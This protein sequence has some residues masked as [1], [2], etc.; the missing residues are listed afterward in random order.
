M[1]GS[2][3]LTHS[4]M[5]TAKSCLKRHYFAYEL[6]I[7]RD[8]DAHYLRTGSAVHKGIDMKAQ[9]KESNDA[10]QEAV[11]GY[12][13]FPAWCV[14]NDDRLDWK[15]ERETAV[16]LLH[17]YFW[18]HKNDQLEV[19]ATE[20]AF[21]I[22]LINSETGA[23]ARLFRLAGKIDKIVRL[24][25]GR[26]A[27]QEHK[28]TGDDISPTSDFWSRLRID[29]Q[30][31]LYVLAARR[32]GH[33]VES[34][35]Y[36][37]IRKPK[38]SPSKLTQS[39]TAQ[40][41]NVYQYCGERFEVAVDSSGNWTVNGVVAELDASG[42]KPAMRETVDMWGARLTQDIV[43]RPEFYFAR[44]EVPRLDTDLKEFEVELWQTAK[45][46]RECQRNGYWFRNTSACTHP[47][48][49]AYRDFCFNGIDPH[50][51][52][53]PGFVRVSDV[54]PELEIKNVS[55]SN[56]PATGEA[57]CEAIAAPGAEAESAAIGGI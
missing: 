37:V 22:P 51:D 11:K 10:I 12:D 30:I 15:I 47:F 17:A 2:N 38:I 1:I 27:I 49:C 32:L 20:Q 55:D 45:L 56:S 5:Q 26:L 7:R 16:R 6:G 25:D 53:P 40:F 31:S 42:K 28:T 43:S 39:E 8:R 44:Q 4:R 9:G 34:I 13:E 57:E 46:L 21:D 50:G 19:V 23:A 48:P 35:L 24:P 3:L 14:S 33:Q 52:L 29:N 54:H 41:V 36:D 18:I